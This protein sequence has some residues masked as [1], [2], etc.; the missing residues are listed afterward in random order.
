M[1][2]KPRLGFIGIG[3]MGEAMKLRLLERGRHV[4]VWHLTADAVRVHRIPA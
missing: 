4:T 1:T 2:R 3:L